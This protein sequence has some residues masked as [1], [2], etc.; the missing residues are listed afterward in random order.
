MN[1]LTIEK[2]TQYVGHYIISVTLEG[3]EFYGYGKGVENALNNLLE[4]ITWYFK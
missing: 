2:S 4:K 1:N 3:C